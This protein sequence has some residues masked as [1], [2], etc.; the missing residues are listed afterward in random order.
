MDRKFTCLI[1]LTGTACFIT[2]DFM[3]ND[4]RF[5]WQAARSP[6]FDFPGQW[7]LCA[8]TL[9]GI[10]P[11]PLRGVKPPLIEEIGFIPIYWS[12]S[13]WGLVL[14]NFFYPGFLVLEEAMVYFTW[15]NY[16]FFP[17]T[18]FLV[19]KKL[20]CGLG[21]LS[22]FF[23]TITMFAGHF[24]VSEYFGNAG[25]VMCCLMILSCLYAD[26]RPLAAGVMLA[27]AMIKPQVAL[28]IC[29]ALFLRKNFKVLFAAAAV[30]LEAWGVAALMTNQTPLKLLSESMAESAGGKSVFSGLFTMLFPD[31][32]FLAMATGMFA[33]TIFILLIQRTS[34]GKEKFFWACPAFLSTTFF[35]YSFHNEFLALLLPALACLYLAANQKIFREKIFWLASMI[36]M[37]TAPYALYLFLSSWID[38]KTELFW[39]TRT[40]FAVILILLGCLM[41]KKFPRECAR[42]LF[43]W[44]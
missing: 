40:I 20:N 38:N 33:G 8:Y 36:F 21:S 23:V 5:L 37:A 3:L 18:A 11:Y 32:K 39:T 35:A 14:G 41:A 9:Q 28:P 13:P 2:N 26:E 43:S 4:L 42:K 25:A 15:L 17:V 16:I 12:T 24:L 30:D 19:S 34:F 6:F 10:D 7:A 1:L 27:L 31:D 29:F 44:Q 22:V